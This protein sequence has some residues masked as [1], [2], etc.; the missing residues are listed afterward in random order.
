MG[1]PGYAAEV[2]SRALKRNIMLVHVTYEKD[3]GT[4][5]RKL[6]F[7]TDVSMDPAEILLYYQSRIRLNFSIATENN[8]PG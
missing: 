7:N 5:S 3:S 2:Y 6:Y 8:T 4:D 1:F